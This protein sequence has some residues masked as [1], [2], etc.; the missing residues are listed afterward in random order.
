METTEDLIKIREQLIDESNRYKKVCE[1][2]QYPIE[3]DYHSQIAD[4]DN[5]II[6][7]IKNDKD[8]R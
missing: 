6:E 5:D 4:I 1:R 8:G 7:S 2:S 3:I